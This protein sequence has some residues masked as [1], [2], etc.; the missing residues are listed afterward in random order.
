MGN[1][2]TVI[3]GLTGQTGAG[4]STVASLLYGYGFAV[5]D[6]DQTARSVTEKGSPVLKELAQ[7]FGAD[8]LNGDGSLDRARLAARAF[9]S[10]EGTELLD[11][12][13]HPEIVRRMLAQAEEAF[14]EGYEAAIL[15]ASQLFEAGLDSRCG[16]IISVVAPDRRRLARIME[17]DGIDAEA[18]KKRMQAQH[19]REFFEENADYVIHNTG[20]L[21]DLA[22]Q[23][24]EIAGI[25]EKT[26]A[27]GEEM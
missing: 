2:H 11:S 15:D 25:I 26:I 23:V 19:D 27:G 3:V 24:R 9:S 22:D 20:T 18:A 7:F 13:T 16:L 17:R 1:R 10:Q 8:I 4:K 5:V 12:I 14:L 21:E 6:A